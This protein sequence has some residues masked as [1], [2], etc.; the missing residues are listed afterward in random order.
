[1]QVWY[2]TA[3]SKHSR[4]QKELIFESLVKQDARVDLQ[5]LRF[6]Y[7]SILSWLSFSLKGRRTFHLRLCNMSSVKST[8]ADG[9]VDNPWRE[10]MREHLSSF[11][12][13]SDLIVLDHQL[14]R[15][16]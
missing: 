8:E 16:R 12:K 3:V 5:D 6:G 11:K 2:S 1:M 13:L 7:A 9:A 10:E 4:K 15:D 14:S